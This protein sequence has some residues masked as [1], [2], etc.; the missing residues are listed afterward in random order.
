MITELAE[1][2]D[3]SANKTRVLVYSTLPEISKLLLEILDF[4]GKKVDFFSAEESRTHDQDFILFQTSDLQ[5]ASLFQPNIALITDEISKEDVRELMKNIVAG[6]VLIFPQFLSDTVG[7]ALHYFR[8]LPF[9]KADFQSENG[10]ALL[11]TEIGP[12]PINA[13]SENLINQL[14][15]LKLLAQQFGVMEE[16][17]YEPVMGIFG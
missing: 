11:D 13:R 16:G 9:E 12:I 10:T 1:L 5:E 7:S 14:N 3:Y 2:I 15:G 6:G 4:N 17:F 8:K